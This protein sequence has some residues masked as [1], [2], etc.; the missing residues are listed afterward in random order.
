MLKGVKRTYCTAEK[1]ILAVAYVLMKFRYYLYR[2]YFEIHMDNQALLFLFKYRLSNARMMRLI[3]VIQEY[4]F[5]I[6]YIKAMENETANILSSYTPEIVKDYQAML[7]N[8]KIFSMQYE[9]SHICMKSNNMKRNNM[10]E[11]QDK[12]PSICQNKSR[13]TPEREPQVYISK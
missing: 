11:K 3:I 9:V 13:C 4:D 7:N 1:E 10:H 2:M 12:E 6:K 8:I 5:T